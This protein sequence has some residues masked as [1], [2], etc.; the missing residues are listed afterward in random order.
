M[1]LQIRSSGSSR[2]QRSTSACRRVSVA[3][4]KCIQV[5]IYPTSPLRG[6]HDPPKADEVPLGVVLASKPRP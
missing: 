3:S 2:E 4:L 1:E 5:L 6:A